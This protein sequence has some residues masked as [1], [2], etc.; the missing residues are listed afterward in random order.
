[1][2]SYL[3]A[4][5]G[6]FIK[7]IDFFKK[8]IAA[9]RTGRANPAILDGVSVEAYGTRT[10]LAGLA[11]ISVTDARSMAIAP[12]D[13][14]ILKDVEK[15]VTEADL[16]FGIVNEGDKIRLTVPAMTEENRRELVKKLNEKL[17]DARIALRQ[18]REEVKKAIEKAEEEKAVS[19]DDKF[20]NIRELDDEVAKKNEELKEIRDKKEKEIM[21]V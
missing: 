10:P 5:Q 11:S 12:W 15:A 2:N 13:K 18:A 19:E 7:A 21:T 16:G 1:M 17:E 20:R 3:Q 9:L 4:K 8:E 6:E 14:N